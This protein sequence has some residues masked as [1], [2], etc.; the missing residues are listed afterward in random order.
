MNSKAIALRNM[1]LIALLA[2]LVAVV[3]FGASLVFEVAWLKA[4][5][6]AAMVGALAD[7][8]AVVAIFRHPLGLPIPHTAI[9]PKNKNAIAKNIALFVRDKFLSE[10]KLREK[11]LE[12]GENAVFDLE[13]YIRNFMSG[14]VESF[15]FEHTFEG[16]K[17]N[18]LPYIFNKI[19]NDKENLSRTLRLEN[20]NYA[21]LLKKRL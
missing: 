8:F 21:E 5:S 3:A 7:W 15:S 2:L 11:F 19:K 9:V 12:K 1:K 4:M 16:F 10:E 6:E 20:I 14:K 13:K 17:E 18:G